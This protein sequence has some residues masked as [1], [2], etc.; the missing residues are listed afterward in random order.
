MGHKHTNSP[1]DSTTTILD[2]ISFYCDN[3]F[4]IKILR[5]N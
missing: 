3:T 2:D 1:T 4:E 5:T